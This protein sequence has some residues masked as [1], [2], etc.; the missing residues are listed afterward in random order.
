MKKVITAV[1]AILLVLCSL[2]SFAACDPG[3]FYFDDEYLSAIVSV[4]LISY[5]NPEQ[6][7]FFSWVPDHTADLKPF[8]ESKVSVL[9]TLDNDKLSDFIDT[10]CECDVLYKYYAFDAPN[11]LCLKLTYAN[12]D[13]VIVSCNGNSFAGYI[14]KFSAD[15]EVADFIGCFSSLYSFETL[16]NDYFQTKI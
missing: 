4:E 10:L 1:L 15:G 14:G 13:F 9:E 3:T 5:V 12:G 2:V 11:G 7:H 16:V 6:T 8:D